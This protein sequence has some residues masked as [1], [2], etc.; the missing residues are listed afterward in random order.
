MSD[1]KDE[2]PPPFK[3]VLHAY[4][5]KITKDQVDRQAMGAQLIEYSSDVAAVRIIKD[6]DG[7]RAQIAPSTKDSWH[8]LFPFLDL[9]E[10]MPRG[11]QED[12]LADLGQGFAERAKKIQE[13]YGRGNY[14]RELDKLYA[15]KRSRGKS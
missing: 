4:G 6:R 10:P 5:Y 14:T 9:I 12:S 2:I 3:S 13:F 15:A 11:A 7:V 8:D 1:L